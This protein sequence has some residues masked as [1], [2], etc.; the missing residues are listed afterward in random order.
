AEF[1]R[2]AAARQA[3]AEQQNLPGVKL[4]PCRN[5]ANQ[6][7]LAGAI[8]PEQRQQLSRAQRQRGAVERDDGAE[9]LFRVGDGQRIHI[10]SVRRDDTGRGARRRNDSA[11][12]GAGAVAGA[13][14]PWSARRRQATA[15]TSAVPIRALTRPTN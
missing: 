6:R 2:R 7:R 13:T 12:G 3:A 9:L 8:R 15:R 1:R 10:V 14:A 11:N 4:Q 5:G